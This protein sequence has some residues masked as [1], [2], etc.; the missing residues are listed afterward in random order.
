MGYNTDYFGIDYT[1]KKNN[2]ELQGKR[3]LVLGSGEQPNL[4]SPIFGFALKVF[5]GQ[6]KSKSG[7]GGFSTGK[8]CIV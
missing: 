7:V 6:Q 3:A 1:F 8:H 4:W 2:V 5:P